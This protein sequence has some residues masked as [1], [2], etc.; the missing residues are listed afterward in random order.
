M[1]HAPPTDFS[2]TT[3]SSDVPMGRISPSGSPAVGRTGGGGGASLYSAEQRMSSSISGATQSGGVLNLDY[4]QS[5]WHAVDSS[6]WR[7]DR[8]VLAR[9]DTGYFDVDT[10][11]VLTRCYKTLLPTED[12]VN[13]VL[14]GVPDL[15]GRSNPP[16]R[17]GEMRETLRAGLT[18]GDVI[19]HRRPVLGADDGHL[20]ALPH[21]KLVELDQGLPHGRVVHV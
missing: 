12:Y 1:I 16:A 17:R 2:N 10:Q 4:C 5:R 3:I 20:L 13:Q 6:E 19:A 15:Y 14:S 8:V 7:A 18:L 9:A 11:T 21:V